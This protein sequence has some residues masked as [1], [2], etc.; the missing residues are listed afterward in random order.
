VRE[1]FGT[2]ECALTLASLGFVISY[3]IFTYV[4]ISWDTQNVVLLGLVLAQLD[5]SSRTG[6]TGPAEERE[7]R[8]DDA[9]LD[10]D[11]DDVELLEPARVP[12]RAAAELA[13]AVARGQAAS[14]AVQGREDRVPMG[15][16]A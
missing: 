14:G 6:T 11:V 12:S 16:G 3:L 9:A 15:L 13:P 10:L 2:R 8:D 4:D 5:R 7:P 1:T